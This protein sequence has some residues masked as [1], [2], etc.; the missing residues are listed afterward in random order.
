MALPQGIFFAGFFL[1]QALCF[2]TSTWALMV[3]MN[4]WGWNGEL[5]QGLLGLQ[6]GCLDGL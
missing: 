6:Q 1:F 2:F 4:G 3:V 5:L